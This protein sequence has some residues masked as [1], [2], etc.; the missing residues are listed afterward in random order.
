[1]PYYHL[2]SSDMY[3]S[4]TYRITVVP[5]LCP[6]IDYI[7]YCKDLVQFGRRYRA[8]E[9]GNKRYCVYIR[10]DNPLNPTK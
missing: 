8:K 9:D 4:D 6:V 3:R 10:F 5:L 1:M 2:V 7:R